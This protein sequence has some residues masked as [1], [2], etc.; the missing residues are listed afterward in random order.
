M[1]CPVGAYTNFE[2]VCQAIANFLADVVAGVTVAIILLP[3]AIAYALIG[4]LPPAAG[5][6][7]AI[8]AAVVAALWGS[9]HHLQSGPTNA[10]SL[11]VLSAL[12]PIAAPNTPEFV[13]AAG[14]M[15]VMVGVFQVLMGV[16]RLDLLVNFD[17]DAVIVGLTAG[18]AWD[19][20]AT[21][22]VCPQPGGGW[23]PR[24]KGLSSSCPKPIF[25]HLCW[26]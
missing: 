3:Q 26:G 17:S 6:F 18:S 24:C 14:L 7:S 15:A 16:A 12:L 25:P 2:E 22:S 11:L 9:S 1:A 5:L 10:L 4:E 13:L 19:S 20:C 23:R 21:S 8:V